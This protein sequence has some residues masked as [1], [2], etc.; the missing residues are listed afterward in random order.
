MNKIVDGRA[1]TISLV[2]LLIVNIIVFS[3]VVIESQERIFDF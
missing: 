3:I 2:V 1:R